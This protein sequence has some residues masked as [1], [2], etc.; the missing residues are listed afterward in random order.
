MIKQILIMVMLLVSIAAGETRPPNVII[1]LTDDQGYADLGCYGS[2][3]LKTPRIDQMAAEGMRFTDFYSPG[4]VCTPTRAGLLTG[5]HPQRLSLEVIPREKPDGS[6]AHV[7]YSRS[8]YGLHPDEVTIAEVLKARGYATGMI[9][10]WHLGDAPQFLPTKQGFDSYFGIPYSND[11]KPSVLLRNDQVVE[12]PVK[13]ET[14][15]ERYTDEAKQFIQSNKDKPF[16]L[17]LAHA[18]PHTPLFVSDRFKG[19]TSRGTYGDL[20]EAL[21]WSTGE[22]LDTLKQLNLD[23]N[24]LVIYT[25]DNG[26]WLFRGEAGGSAFPLRG[27]KGTTYEGGMRIPFIAR[28]PGHIPAAK[29]SKEPLTHLDLFPTICALTGAKPSDRKIDGADISSILLGDANAKNPHEAIFYYGD[30]CLNAVRSGR[31]KFKVQT[32]LQQETEYG[33]YESPDAKIPP[34]LYDL[35]FDPAEQKNVAADHPDIV[36]RLQ[37]Y[38]HDQ[39]QE[40]GDRRLNIVG[41]GVRPCGVAEDVKKAATGEVSYNDR[42][43]K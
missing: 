43:V 16:F 36:K 18:A 20:I 14:L 17:Y 3:T 29:T 21:D 34:A 42:K 8:R 37:K 33:K 13:Q 39:R 22:I 23:D 4:P 26:P 30:G 24:T 1:I 10:K 40:L 35:E 27:G 19:R 11:M 15:V 2:T 38:L 25:S 41:K 9:G 5:A 7:L 6:D 31:W 28:W 12:E 32:A